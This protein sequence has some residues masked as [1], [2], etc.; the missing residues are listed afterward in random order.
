MKLLYVM[1]NIKL[2]LLDNIMATKNRLNIVYPTGHHASGKTEMCEYLETSYGFSII[3][4]GAMMRQMY[5]ERRSEYSDFTIEA[6]AKLKLSE[7]VLFFAKRLNQQIKISEKFSQNIAINGMR[8]LIGI[9]Q[10]Q[11]QIPASTHTILW[12]DAPITILH[13]RYMER[14]QKNVTLDNFIRMTRKDTSLGLDE[15]EPKADYRIE[16]IED[17]NSFR[18]TIDNILRTLGIDTVLSTDNPSIPNEL[19]YE[20]QE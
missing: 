17:I 6:F 16:N 12:L 13:K 14:E 11:D 15:I 18:V 8:S 1:I 20:D 5:Q 4:T 3:E 9:R 10:M 7:D 19:V 2:R